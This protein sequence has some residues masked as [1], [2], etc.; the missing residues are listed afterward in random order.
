MP[1]GASQTEFDVPD[2]HAV[3]TLHERLANAPGKPDYAPCDR[4]GAWDHSTV[5]RLLTSR[6]LDRLDTLTIKPHCVLD[7]GCNSRERLQGLHERYPRA[8]VIGIGWSVSQLRRCGLRAPS[9]TRGLF[10]RWVS[11]L[12]ARLTGA[13]AEHSVLLSAAPDHLPLADASVDLVI[14]DQLLPWC[15]NPSSVF[16]EVLRVLKP[17][18]AFFW[19]SAGPDTLGEYRRQWQTIDTYAHVW[20]LRDMHDLGDDMLRSGF[21]APVIDRE[22]LTINYASVSDLI[23]DLR[24]NSLVNIAAGRRRGLMS[25]G[26]QQRLLRAA[27]ADYVATFELIQGHGWK[28]ETPVRP[29]AAGGGA[30]V[31]VPVDAIERL[32]RE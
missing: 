10:G 20:G 15:E 9:R 5:P 11:G 23:N 32:A 2:S 31:F 19:S 8:T 4:D 21:S 3:C 28:S 17:G 1:Q 7:L 30:E 12:T 14:A 16:A 29:A 6:L 24:G 22:N 27:A 25:P 13:T 26:V 18:G